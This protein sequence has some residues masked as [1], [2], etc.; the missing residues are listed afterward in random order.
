ML[1]TQA[2]GALLGRLDLADLALSSLRAR[3]G[4]GVV[5]NDLPDE[6]V[7]VLWKAN[8]PASYS[9]IRRGATRHDRRPSRVLPLPLV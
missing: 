6:G 3:H 5:E 4:M 7:V 2:S 8:D 1:E 9:T